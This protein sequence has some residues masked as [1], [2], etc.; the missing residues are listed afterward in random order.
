LL[1]L[2]KRFR[3]TRQ[4]FRGAAGKK[5][6]GG[7]PAGKALIQVCGP[8]FCSKLRAEPAFKA[9]RVVPKKSERRG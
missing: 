5:Q 8:D 4:L 2:R 6:L 9:A 7:L 3:G 1:V